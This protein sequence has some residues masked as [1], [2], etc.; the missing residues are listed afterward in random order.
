MG[1]GWTISGLIRDGENGYLV[2]D[3]QTMSERLIALCSDPVKR[4]AVGQS[5]RDYAI[6]YGAVNVKKELER[7]YGEYKS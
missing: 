1:W 7:I 6:D 4:N 5:A 3:A 2:Q